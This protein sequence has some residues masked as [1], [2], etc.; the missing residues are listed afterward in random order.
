M[1]HIKWRWELPQK[2]TQILIAVDIGGKNTQKQD[3]IRIWAREGNGKPL[4]CSCLENPTDRGACWAAIYGVAQSRARLKWLSSS[5]TWTGPHR[6]S[7]DQPSV[8][9]HPR[10]VTWTV[11]PSEEKDS[12][13]SDSRKKK[14]YSH[15][16]TCSADSLVWFC[17]F[18]FPFPPLCCSCWFYWHDEI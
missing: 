17:F 15:V 6:R 9:G 11:T 14:N 8:G 2:K 16:L 1:E 10:E 12:E 3:Q 18:F 4:Q 7:R 5:R 13:S